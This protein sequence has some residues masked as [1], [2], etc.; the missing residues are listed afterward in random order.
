MS[1]SEKK[2]EEKERVSEGKR[3]KDQE[4]EVNHGELFVP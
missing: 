1:R 2:Q 4:N 3:W